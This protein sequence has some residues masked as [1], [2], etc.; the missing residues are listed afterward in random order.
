L[1]FVELMAKKQPDSLIDAFKKNPNFSIE[2]SL[3]IC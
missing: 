3:K 2:E 1:K